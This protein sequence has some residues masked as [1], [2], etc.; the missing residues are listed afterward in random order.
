MPPTNRLKPVTKAAFDAAYDEH[1]L[2]KEFVEYADYYIHSRRRYWRTYQQLLRLELSAGLTVAEIGGGQMAVLLSKLH[3]VHATAADVNDR[4]KDDL[5]A[6]GIGFE[7]ANLYTGQMPDRRYDLV[8]CLEVIEHIPLP[9]SQVLERLASITEGDGHLFL[10][11]PNGMRLR[12]I[13][14]LASGREVLDFYRYP[15][16]GQGLGHQHEYT[17]RQMV[18]QAKRAGLRIHFAEQQDIAWDGANRSARLMRRVLKPFDVLPHLRES[19]V[20][21]CSPN[22]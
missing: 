21:A 22:R 13:L 5:A 2:A 4:P 1:I 17:L 20:I 12:N 3:D 7:I 16:E 15:E 10:T 19:L 8:I 18:W 9:P 6:A 14:Y 11:T